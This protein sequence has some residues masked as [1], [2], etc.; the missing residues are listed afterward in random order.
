MQRPVEPRRHLLD[1]RRLAGAVI[2]LDHHAPVVLEAG[3]DGERHLPVEHV[4]VVHVGHV[5]VRLGVGRHLEIGVDA[6][7]LTYGHLH[8]RQSGHPGLGLGAHVAWCSG[9]LAGAR[10]VRRTVVTTSIELGRSASDEPCLF[11]IVIGLDDFAQL[12]LGALVAAVGV[13][14]VA[15][16]Q[17]LEARLDLG[18]RRRRR[19]I[20]RIQRLWLQ[21]LEGVAPPA[22]RAGWPN[23][24]K[25]RRAGRETRRPFPCMAP[26]WRVPCA[27][28]LAPAFQVGRWPITLSFW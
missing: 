18:L 8:V 11:Q 15:F 24:R 1:M 13:G 19:E 21:R 5:I 9:W 4:V 14:V 6:E 3:E 25:R 16:D 28:A 27:Q 2:A 7:H 20:E 17:L 10:H 26:P 23:A 12:V 22:P